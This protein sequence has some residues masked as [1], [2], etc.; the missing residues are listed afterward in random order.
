MKV[1]RER[2]VVATLAVLAAFG[3]VADGQKHPARSTDPYVEPESPLVR[4]RLEWFK[5]QKLCLMMHLGLYSTMGITESWPLVTKDAFW[6]RSD[7]EWAREMDDAEVKE[8]YFALNRSFNPIRFNAAEVAKKAKDCGFRYVSFTTK[9]HDGFCLWDTKC[10]DYKT[11]DPS[12]PY[13]TNPNADIVKSLFNAC[14]AE[15]LGISCYFSKADFHHEDY[16][17]DR[18]VGRYT[19]RWPT[20][21][22]RK[23]PEKWNRFREFT[24]NQILELVGNYG[25]VDM[26]WLD[27]AWFFE[28]N[29]GCDLNM[30]DIVE[31]ARKI[32]PDLI[33]VDRASGDEFMN[34]KTPE[35][36][37]P[38]RPLPFPWE[39]C[40][41][42]ADGWGYHYDDVY[43]SP[44]QL[45][46]LLVDVVAK[47]GNLALNVGP[48]PDGRL[49]RPAVERMEAMGAWLKKNGEA[50]YGTRAVEPYALKNWRF[51]RGHDGRIYAIRLWNE[52]ENPRLGVLMNLEKDHPEVLSVTHLATGRSMRCEKAVG[53]YEQGVFVA[54]PKDFVRDE[55]ADVFAIT[56][57][58]NKESDPL[59]QEKGTES[60]K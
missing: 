44:R 13:S 25:P 1:K 38:E 6:A 23:Q 4:E 40:I 39:T 21:D 32:K 51:T 26:L 46:H 50:I 10:T 55:F 12:C 18:G 33:V 27:G 11:T 47:G 37:V 49:P 16:W 58:P 41:T 8:Q 28:R 17:E 57:K 3:A 24:K 30:K 15:G 60:C 48:M 56:Y 53:D 31:S 9:H 52:G 22:V 35:Q 2:L 5:D 19:D 14:R 29:C 54:F 45:I 43:K 34:I 7:M 42:M 36:C 20:Y 59:L